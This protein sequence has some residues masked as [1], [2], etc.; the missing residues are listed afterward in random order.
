MD[1]YTNILIPAGVI[2]GYFLIK[3]TIPRFAEKIVD[4]QFDKKLETHKHE[5]NK[6]TEEAKFNYQRLLSDFNL[7]SVKKHEHY[8]ELYNDLIRAHGSVMHLASALKQRYTYDFFDEND[9]RNYLA[10][11][12]TPSGRTEQLISTWKSD[13]KTGIKEIHDHEAYIEEW[14]AEKDVNKLNNTYLSSRL[15]LSSELKALM[16]KLVPDLISLS[17]NAKREYQ[18]IS[19]NISGED[20]MQ[21]YEE[22]KKLKV[23]INDTKDE[24]IVKMQSELSVGYYKA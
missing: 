10:K 6:L 4:N 23:Q 22:S 17:I 18:P 2:G 1:W 13:P 5:L 24:I 11:L 3:H 14:N 12:G 16:E 15:Y 9:M 19:G 8:I 20:F 7:Y 21:L